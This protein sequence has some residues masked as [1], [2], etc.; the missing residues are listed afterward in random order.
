MHIGLILRV[1]A[2]LLIIIS[3]F[4]I[5]PVIFALYYHEEQM[6]PHFLLPMLM[7]L[8]ISLPI[9]PGNRSEKKYH[10]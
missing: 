7:V 4:M 5:F 6:I 9:I 10:D 3:F 8:I 2:I 1:L